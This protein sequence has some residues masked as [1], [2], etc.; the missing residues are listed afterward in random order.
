MT[1][2]PQAVVH[3]LN[4]ADASPGDIVEISLPEGAFLWA[5]VATYLMPVLLL[6][7]GAVVGHSTRAT[8]GL[9]SDAASGLGALVG[10]VVGVFGTWLASR[11]AARTGLTVPHVT[12]VLVT[13]KGAPFL[14]MEPSGND[15]V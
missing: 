14:E 9:S 7:A 15:T 10:M 3:A 6:V 12:K 8:L 2:D 4:D 1:G 11:H 5:S 13:K